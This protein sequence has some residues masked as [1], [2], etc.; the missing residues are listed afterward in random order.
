MLGTFRSWS[1]K[2]VSGAGKAWNN[3]GFYYWIYRLMDAAARAKQLYILSHKASMNKNV[4]GFFVIL[5]A[6]LDIGI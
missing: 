6:C 4:S 3:P 2:E 5:I 1:V